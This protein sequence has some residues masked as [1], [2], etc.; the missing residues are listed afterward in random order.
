M[1]PYSFSLTKIVIYKNL[2]IEL[3]TKENTKKGNSY[4]PLYNLLE[5]NY[6]IFF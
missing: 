1:L 2:K 3:I 6:M 4:F 5:E